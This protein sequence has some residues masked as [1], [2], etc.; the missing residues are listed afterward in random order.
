MFRRTEADRLR[1]IEIYW[2]KNH[3]YLE[4][5]KA[6]AIQWTDQLGN[7]SSIGITILVEGAG[8]HI[9]FNY[10]QTESDGT[11]KDFDYDI[12]LTSTPCNF[13]GKRF[14]F[15]CPLS[16]D[17]AYCGKKVGVLYKA[18]DYFGCRHCYNLTYRS[19]NENRRSKLFPIF[20]ILKTHQEMEDF[21]PTVKR[22]TY[23]RNP[24]KK[25]LKL[26]KMI[27]RLSHY[28]QLQRSSKLFR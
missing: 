23:A 5:W 13:G 28:N 8:G 22:F 25:Q 3:G 18:G 16:K 17:G 10:L 20:A 26:D 4:N 9:H 2:L 11:K 1:K 27:S 6:G 21:E 14:W 24:T 7:K 15:I 12:R 19:K